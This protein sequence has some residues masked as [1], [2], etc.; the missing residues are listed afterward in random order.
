MTE[1]KWLSATDP[2]KM[3]EWLRHSREATERK[4]RLFACA[5]CRR[6]WAGIP[7]AACRRAAETAEACADGLLP[8][9]RM[10]AAGKAASASWRRRVGGLI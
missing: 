1:S 6:V 10:L 4:L 7:I 2:H 9:S 5:L 8:R 3:L